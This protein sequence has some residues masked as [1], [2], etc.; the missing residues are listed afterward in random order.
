MCESGK[1]AK[2][3]NRAFP[4]GSV[5]TMQCTMAQITISSQMTPKS[6]LTV[7][8]IIKPLFRWGLLE[9]GQHFSKK[10]SRAGITRV[11]VGSWHGRRHVSIE[12]N[13]P[14][15]GRIAGFSVKIGWSDWQTGGEWLPS[16][17]LPTKL[18]RCEGN[19]GSPLQGKRSH[20]CGFPRFPP[21]F[22]RSFPL[23][24][25]NRLFGHLF[26]H[27]ACNRRARWPGNWPDRFLEIWGKT[28]IHGRSSRAARAIVGQGRRRPLNSMEA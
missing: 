4:R 22:F 13:P 24:T 17:P 21:M 1:D 23:D 15:L 14:L 18:I 9:T 5:G 3:L 27:A 10:R 26:W 20:G 25:P 16:C 19:G 28:G 8:S 12:R 2:R 11:C 7:S 6:P